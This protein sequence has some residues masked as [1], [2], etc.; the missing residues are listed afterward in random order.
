MIAGGI[1]VKIETEAHPWQNKLAWTLRTSTRITDVNHQIEALFSGGKQ[2]GA[3]GCLGPSVAEHVPQ[4]RR[5][6]QVCSML[7]QPTHD[8]S[9][10]STRPP[11]P[12]RSGSR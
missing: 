4:L 1:I 6:V 9:R 7:L 12:D 8:F 3:G 5:R 11:A 2:E 10:A